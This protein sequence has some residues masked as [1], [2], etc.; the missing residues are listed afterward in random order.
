MWA[1]S[2][3]RLFTLQKEG[4]INTD[5][6]IQ[7]AEPEKEL[8]YVDL[9]RPGPGPCQWS[10]RR[11]ARA[12]VPDDGGQQHRVR[13]CDVWQPQVNIPRTPTKYRFF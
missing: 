8:N 10:G 12:E 2:R 6:S 4:E 5:L 13:Q 1:L 3:T 11:Q 7:K 9:H